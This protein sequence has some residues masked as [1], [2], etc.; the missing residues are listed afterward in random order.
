MLASVG[1]GGTDLNSRL[2]WWLGPFKTWRRRGSPPEAE[3]PERT[4]T[5]VLV[6]WLLL[7][8]GLLAL[9]AFMW[10]F[11][12]T[13]TVVFAILGLLLLGGTFTRWRYDRWARE[14]EERY[15]REGVRFPR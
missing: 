9:A 1:M 13:L 15:T 2:M 11:I 14:A 6:V 12:P 7:A 8:F 5:A 4:P 10:F 3:P